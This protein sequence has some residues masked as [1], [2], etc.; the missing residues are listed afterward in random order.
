M[1]AYLY[2]ERPIYIYISRRWHF[3]PRRSHVGR[4]AVGFR[5]KLFCPAKK[6]TVAL[7]PSPSCLPTSYT[8]VHGPRR[9]T[10]VSAG[11]AET[12]ETHRLR[13]LLYS[14][15]RTFFLRRAVLRLDVAS[16]SRHGASNPHSSG[17]GRRV[18]QKNA[19]S[20]KI[21]LRGPG[22][23]IAAPMGSGRGSAAGSENAGADPDRGAGEP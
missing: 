6:K 17:R 15:S 3:R 14:G 12:P 16:S 7:H 19:V 2:R 10:T 13:S 8:S 18:Q 9:R 23:R 21:G 22:R 11:A 4:T 1:E 20:K 5:Q